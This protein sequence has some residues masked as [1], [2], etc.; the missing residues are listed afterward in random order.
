[1]I[2]LILFNWATYLFLFWILVI[3]IGNLWPRPRPTSLSNVRPSS[4]P[5][6]ARRQMYVA[7]HQA[8]EPDAPS[9]PARSRAG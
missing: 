7:T 5:L 4:D 1:M 6:S 3:A 2:D 9:V 8:L